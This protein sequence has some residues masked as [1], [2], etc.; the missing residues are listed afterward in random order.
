MTTD[1]IH[2]DHTRQVTVFVNLLDEESGDSREVDKQV[3][4]GE[5]K[6]TRIKEELGVA[7]ASALWVQKS[8]GRSDPLADHVSYDVRE[9]DHFEV[10]FRGGVS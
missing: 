9:G 4:S 6:V 3:E 2:E 8:D 7:E 1:A 5:T 10:I